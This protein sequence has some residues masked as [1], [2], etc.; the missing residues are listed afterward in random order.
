MP[1][2]AKVAQ[3]AT[4]K[5][6]SIEATLKKLP[7]LQ[8]EL[9]K[10]HESVANKLQAILTELGGAPFPSH[11]EAVATTRLVQELMQQLGKRAK[12]PNTGQPCNFRCTQS[13]R[14]KVTTFQFD[15]V[16]QGKRKV[17]AAGTVFPGIQLIDAPQDRRKQSSQ[18]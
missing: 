11:E 6:K 7:G 1:R 8:K 9:K 16:V 14:G 5:H 10:S 2:K 18:R 4:G 12:C 13:G 15:R 17:T 3:P